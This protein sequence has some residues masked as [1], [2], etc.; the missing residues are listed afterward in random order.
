MIVA[1]KKNIKQFAKEILGVE[2]TPEKEKELINIC[3]K[4]S[5]KNYRDGYEHKSF[6]ITKY[7][8]KID[9][10]IGTFGV[11]NLF[12]EIPDLFYCN[13]GDTYSTTILCYKDKLYIGCWGDIAE[14]YLKNI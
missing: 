7:M 4:D 8:K 12:P 6:A 11:E 2:Y 3:T 10:I 1:N 14:K 13:A 9:E 5:Y